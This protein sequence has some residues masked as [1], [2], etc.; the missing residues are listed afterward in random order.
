M[1]MLFFPFVSGHF[2]ALE[3]HIFMQILGDNT[4]FLKAAKGMGVIH[5]PHF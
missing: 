4:Q 3:V 1:L 5:T 2:S